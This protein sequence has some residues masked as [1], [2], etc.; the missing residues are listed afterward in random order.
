M[1]VNRQ[2]SCDL[3]RE[4]AVLDPVFGGDYLIGLHW[5]ANTRLVEAS[6]WRQVER[7]IC[8]KCLTALQAFTPVCGGGMR[9][10]KGGPQCQSDHK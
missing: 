4:R 8:P 6:D 7:H 10:C 3:C 1:A 2:Y 9:G 5:E